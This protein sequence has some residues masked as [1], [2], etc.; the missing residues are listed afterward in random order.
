MPGCG[1]SGTV[2]LRA[3]GGYLGT[4]DDDA[5]VRALNC[6]QGAFYVELAERREKD[7]RFVYGW[8]KHRVV[9]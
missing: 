5:L 9:L 8:L 6:L 7:E 4:R 3:F 2:T 1:G